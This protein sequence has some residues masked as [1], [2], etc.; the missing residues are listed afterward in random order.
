MTTRRPVVEAGQLD[1]Q[2]RRLQLVE[3]G[4]AADLLELCSRRVYATM[5]PQRAGTFG[6]APIGGSIAP[7]SPRHRE[8]LGGKEREVAAVS[9]VPARPELLVVPSAWAASSRTGTRSAS[10]SATG[11]RFPNRSS[12]TTAFVRGVSAAL[13]VWGD[14]ERL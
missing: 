11:D 9:T 7:P 4:V 1:P 14:V 3:P 6:D 13:T 8:V 2:D 12:A 5:E 10:I